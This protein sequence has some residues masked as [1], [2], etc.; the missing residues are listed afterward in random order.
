MQRRGVTRFVYTNV[1]RDGMLE[2]PDLDEVAR[3]VGGGPRALP[4]LGRDRLAGRPA[5][6][7]RAAAREPRRRDLG[8]GALRGPLQRRRGPGE[9]EAARADAAAAGDPVP[10]RRQGPRGQGRRVREPA[11]RRRPGRAG[12]ALP[13]R[14]RATRSSSSTSPR[15]TSSA[16]RSRELARRCADD[17]FIPF[18]I[19]GGVRSAEDA[20]AVLDAGADKVSVNSAAVARPEL[21]GELAEVFGAQCVV[22][23]IDARRE[24][25]GAYGVYVER[26]PHAGRARRGR[27]GARGRR[28]RGGGDPADE[29]GPRRHRGRLRAR[30]DARGGRR[31]RRAGDRLGRRR[32]RWT[33]SSRRSSAGGAD[34]VLCASIFHYGQL[35]R[36]R[37]QGARCARPG[38]PVRDCDRVTATCASASRR[39]PGMDRLLPAL[40]GLPPAYLVGGAVRDLLRGARTRSTSTS[41]SRA[42][43]ARSARAL[44]ERLGG[45]GARARALRHRDG[46]APEPALRPGHHPD[47]RPT[48]QPGALPRVVPAPLGED[49]RRRDF[50]INAM[51]IGADRRRPRPPLRP[52]RRPRRPRGG[53]RP[54][55]ARPQLPRRPDPAAARASATRRGSASRST[56]TPSALARAAVAEDA[57]ATVSG[58][59]V[60]DELMDLLGETRRRPRR[61]AARPRDRPRAPPRARPGPRAG[62]LRVARRGRDRRRPRR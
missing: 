8:Q 55:P 44:A 27:V 36:P 13:G 3:V 20:Q 54:R 32:R 48:T 31:R 62:G 38:I 21:L 61:A 53:R 16:R 33:T 49:L 35:H 24:A 17:V 11:R 34:A 46:V 37:G 56:R 2:G 43:R 1:D 12:R 15:R 4:L 41:P 57:L 30:A 18:T 59:R 23:A 52:A 29:H 19:G 22:L 26:R 6:A 7:A 9:L 58:E 25:D 50:T 60:R 51:A 14:G 45:D 5:R 39:L 28:A 40:E 42:T 10:R 47:A